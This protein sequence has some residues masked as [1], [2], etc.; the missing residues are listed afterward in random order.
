MVFEQSYPTRKMK[1]QAIVHILGSEVYLDKVARF[2]D[3]MEER[4]TLSEKEKEETENMLSCHRCLK[5]FKQ[6]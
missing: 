6:K 4:R 3:F 1:K 2:N 5:L